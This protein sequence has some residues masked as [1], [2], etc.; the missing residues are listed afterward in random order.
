MN[1]VCFYPE[2]L[3]LQFRCIHKSIPPGS[4][5]CSV[6]IQSGI[7][8][9]VDTCL[10][11]ALIH[12]FYPVQWKIDLNIWLNTWICWHW[13]SCYMCESRSRNISHLLPVGF[14]LNSKA[15][16][17]NWHRAFIKSS[18]KNDCVPSAQSAR[19]HNPQLHI[20]FSNHQVTDSDTL[21]WH[22]SCALLY[23]VNV[24]RDH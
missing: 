16:I 5:T 24:H 12:P 19:T 22:S 13:S 15:N 20:T 17:N 11:L 3:W 7:F 10:D 18:Q 21:I 23:C 14:L 9:Y 1:A 4:L 2:L 8:H 6:Q